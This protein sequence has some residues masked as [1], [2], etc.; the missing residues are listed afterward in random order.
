MWAGCTLALD[1]YHADFNYIIEAGRIEGTLVDSV[2]LS[3]ILSNE[4]GKTI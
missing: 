1:I 2:P 3:G 4:Q